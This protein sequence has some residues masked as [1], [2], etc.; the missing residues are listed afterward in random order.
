MIISSNKKL[1]AAA[2][3]H[4]FFLETLQLLQSPSANV[5]RNLR[6]FFRNES[7]FVPKKVLVVAKL[8]RYHF[9]KLREPGLNEAELKL[10]LLERGS[11]YDALLASHLANKSVVNQIVQVLRKL[12]MEYRIID[13]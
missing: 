5:H 4:D 13:R 10:K 9:E 3:V 12:N 6:F 2:N 8:S 7:S 11:D 1:I